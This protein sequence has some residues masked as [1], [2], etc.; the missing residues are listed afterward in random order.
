LVLKWNPD[1]GRFTRIEYQGEY[2]PRYLSASGY[3]LRDS[4]IY[5]LGGFG[6]KSG[7]QSISP[8]YYYELLSYSLDEGTFSKVF[9]FQATGEDFCFSNTAY[10]DKTNKLYALR[11]SK[12]QFENTLQLVQIPIDQPE[13]LE[14]GNRLDYTFLDVSSYSDLH[15]SKA[16]NAL[17]S[18]ST[19]T[20]DDQTQVSVKSIAFPP[21][22]FSVKAT[23]PMK[24]SNNIRLVLGGLLLSLAL[25]T[26]VYY[27]GRRRDKKPMRESAPVGPPKNMSENSIILFGGLQVFDQTGKDI[28]G[29]FSPLPR[30]LFLYVLL[31]S[32]RDDKGVSNNTL[33]ETFW[34][35]KSVENARNNR[36]VNVIKLKSVLDNLASTT[37]SKDTGY[38]KFYFDPSLVHIDYYEYLQIARQKSDLNKEQID[39]LLSMID[40]KPFLKNTHADWLDPF[41]SEVSND[42]IDMLL[43]Y[44]D[45]SDDDSDFLLH[46]T[47]CI[48]LCD[49]VSEEALKVQCRLLIKQGKLS[50]AKKSYTRFVNEYKTLYEDTYELSF[51]EVIE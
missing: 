37:L 11:Y 12:H 1:S 38:L 36:S 21:Q 16:S 23:V 27:R 28:T 35:D 9:D 45:K 40:N 7:K 48:F 34:F 18:L 29:Q 39:K 8:D 6:S 31:H 20:S 14:L 15:F 46:L 4:L 13:I 32:I 5:F 49:S 25:F 19:Y 3:N 50:L 43:K 24:T 17:V 42:I 41:K 44:I 47:N 33:Y 10:I 51:K 26:L 22:P 2:Q 30:K